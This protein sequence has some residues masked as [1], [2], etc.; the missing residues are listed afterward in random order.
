MVTQGH[1]HVCGE[2]EIERPKDWQSKG[3]PPRVWGRDYS[4]ILYKVEP[5]DTPTC[6]GKSVAKLRAWTRNG[7]TP[8]CVGK[9]KDH[10]IAIDWIGGHP[11]VCGEELS[12]IQ[13]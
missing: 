6:V 10:L 5:R 12:S 1:P 8:T 4:G 7:D 3:T 2:E 9:R 11:H 13:K